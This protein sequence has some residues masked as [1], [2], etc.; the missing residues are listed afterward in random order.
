MTP[1]WVQS[2]IRRLLA[3]AQD[4]VE[5]RQFLNVAFVLNE[6]ERLALRAHSNELKGA[7]MRRSDSVLELLNL[8]RPIEEKP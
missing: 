2:R 6:A 4:Q 5:K 7:E 3:Y 8:D 1:E